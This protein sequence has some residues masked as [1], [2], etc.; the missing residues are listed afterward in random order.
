MSCVDEQVYVGGRVEDGVQGGCRDVEAA[1]EVRWDGV[2]G[3]DFAEPLDVGLCMCALCQVKVVPQ[4]SVLI[5]LHR[6]SCSIV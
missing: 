2:C 4:H 6:F 1:S 5:I 3:I